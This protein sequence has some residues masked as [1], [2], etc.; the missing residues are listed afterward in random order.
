MQNDWILDESKIVMFIETF[1][2][3]FLFL[4]LC[5]M[6]ASSSGGALCVSSGT[7]RDSEMKHW[8][9]YMGPQG[10][11]YSGYAYPGLHLL[12]LCTWF[13]KTLWEFIIY[14]M[15]KLQ[16]PSHACFC[17][18]GQRPFFSC[19]YFCYFKFFLQLIF[20]FSVIYFF[21]CITLSCWISSWSWFLIIDD[22]TVG[23]N[24]MVSELHDSKYLAGT[25]G[26]EIY[27][28][29]SLSLSLS[30]HC[31]NSY[32]YEMAFSC[33]DGLFIQLLSTVLL[34]YLFWKYFG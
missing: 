34:S 16:V 21:F 10:L 7:M 18:F 23:T 6:D 29:V 32:I 31:V 14:S 22:Y 9:S 8:D 30:P 24:E 5:P 3:F 19:F 12:S 2:F 13:S 25:N 27:P 1:P 28:T 4:K 17:W 33:F 26:L 11:Y 20:R 15:Y